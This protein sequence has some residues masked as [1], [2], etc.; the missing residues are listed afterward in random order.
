M[1]GLSEDDRGMQVSVQKLR[2]GA[3]RV[4]VHRLAEY[5]PDE[6]EKTDGCLR[7]P[8]GYLA[9]CEF[10]QNRML[11]NLRKCWSEELKQRRPVG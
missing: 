2:E 6:K 7:H 1:S 9:A 11:R 5:R 10:C 8:E 4:R 3:E